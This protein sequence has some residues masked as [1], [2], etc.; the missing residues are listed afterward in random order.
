MSGELKG[1]TDDLQLILGDLSKKSKGVGH[2][3]VDMQDQLYWSLA[4]QRQD[5]SGLNKSSSAASFD[6]SLSFYRE[7]GYIPRAANGIAP[8][9][10]GLVHL[11]ENE[12]RRGFPF[13]SG[14]HAPSQSVIIGKLPDAFLLI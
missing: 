5:G 6:L 3:A 2:L 14:I 10:G 9:K 8:C 12:A 13:Q 4:L 1:T 11:C 7:V